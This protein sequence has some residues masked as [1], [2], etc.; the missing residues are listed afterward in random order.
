MSLKLAFL[1][2]RMGSTRLPGKAL[3]PLAGKS[4]LERAVDRLRAASRLDGMAILT[5]TLDRDDVIAERALE[6][7]IPC[8]R[9]PALDVLGRFREAAERFKPDIIVRATADNPLI[10]IGSID[11][12]VGA[13]EAG[14]LEFCME[15]DL[16]VGAATE[17]FTRT[18]LEKADHSTS[19]SHHREHVTTYMKENPACFRIAYLSPPPVL[20]RPSLRLTIDTIEDFL[21]VESLVREVPDEGPPLPL[22]RYLESP[23]SFSSAS[24]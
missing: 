4:I 6:W 3:L 15:A 7:E 18:A 12:I 24:V 8:H 10:D 23:R 17:A 19:L 9:G 11:R 21:F 22:S 13:V 20:R 1:P 2:V 14:N 5:T 16:P